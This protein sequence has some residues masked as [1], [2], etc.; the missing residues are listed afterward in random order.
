MKLANSHLSYCSNIHPGEAWKDH[1]QE[2]KTNLPKIKAAV[3]A[4]Q[5]FGLGL[6]LSAQAAKELSEPEALK[7]FQDWLKQNHIYVFTMNGFPYGD[8]HIKEVK[9]KVHA[10]DWTSKERFEYTKNLFDILA[11]LLP[12]GQE[13]GIST[14]PLSYRD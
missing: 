12:E 1:F 3:S 8:F 10:P 5:D 9:D 4:D 14:S 6:R 7:E 11:H 13:G 2:L